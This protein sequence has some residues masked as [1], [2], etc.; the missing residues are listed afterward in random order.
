[1]LKHSGWWKNTRVPKLDDVVTATGNAEGPRELLSERKEGDSPAAIWWFPEISVMTVISSAAHFSFVQQILTEKPL[2][3]KPCLYHLCFAENRTNG[4]CSHGSYIPVKGEK[5]HRDTQE[6]FRRWSRALSRPSVINQGYFKSGGQ[7]LFHQEG[8][9]SI[10]QVCMRVRN[11]WSE[12]LGRKDT[13]SRGN[14]VLC[15]H[16]G[17]R[18]GWNVVDEQGAC[19]VKLEMQADIRL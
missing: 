8:N 5:K 1:M 7:R 11:R 10:K 2:C 15:M 6:K 18:C 16:R 14:R 13:P 17:S 4:T 12:D 19:K 9:I 3:V